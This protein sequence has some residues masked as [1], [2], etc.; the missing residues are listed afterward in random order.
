MEKSIVRPVFHVIIDVCLFTCCLEVFRGVGASCCHDVG[1]YA[2][3]GVSPSG[4]VDLAS[5]AR[6][7]GHFEWEALYV[8]IVVK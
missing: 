4:F 2:S 7:S 6:R 8:S 3:A 5:P 1:Y